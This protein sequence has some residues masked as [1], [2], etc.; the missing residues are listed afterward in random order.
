MAGFKHDGPGCC[1]CGTSGTPCSSAFVC[2]S[3]LPVCV[4]AIAGGTLTM[5]YTPDSGA[6]PVTFTGSSNS[7]CLAQSEIPGT[8]TWS[9]SSTNYLP[10]TGSVHITTCFPATIN[11]DVYPNTYTLTATGCNIG[12]D[13]TPITLTASGGITGTCT[14]TGSGGT[15]SCTITATAPVLTPVTIAISADRYKAI[16]GTTWNACGATINIGADTGYTCCSSISTCK[17][18]KD[19][20][21]LHTEHG[22]FPYTQAAGGSA[23][24]FTATINVTGAPTSGAG[25]AH[26]CAHPTSLVDVLFTFAIP[27]NATSLT[28]TYTGCGGTPTSCDNDV[29]GEEVNLS[30][31]A[32]GSTTGIACY[33]LTPA[34]PPG[35]IA[36]GAGPLHANR[37]WTGGVSISEA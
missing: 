24:T 36:T 11:V 6:T 7:H 4:P 25:G 27:C 34:C 17:P 19:S 22:D 13:G 32:A 29:P 30:G 10:S 8:L 16:S 3:F 12:S 35:T 9:W 26:D 2:L 15:V 1:G 37:Y 31:Y 18:L 14:A 5:T 28:I 33:I 20:R 23:S 21:I